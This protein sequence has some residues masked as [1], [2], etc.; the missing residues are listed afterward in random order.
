MQFEK[1]EYQ[2]EA[3]K[4][5]HETTARRLGVQM[6]TGSGKTY[7]L[8][9]VIKRWSREGKRVLFVVDKVILVD[10]TIDTLKALQIAVERL[11]G[12]KKYN[13]NANVFVATRQGLKSKDIE[14]TFDYVVYDEVHGYRT[15]SIFDHVANLYDNPQMIGLSATLHLPNGKPMAMF[16]ETYTPTTTARLIDD[17]HLKDIK[18]FRIQDLSD[19]INTGLVTVLDAGGD[20]KSDELESLMLTKDVAGKT[21]KFL[22][23]KKSIVFATGIKHAELLAEQYANRGFNTLTYHSKLSEKERTEAVNAMMR[24]DLDIIIGVDAL[25]SGFD[26]PII[27]TVVIARPT[28][29]HCIYRQMVGRGLRKFNGVD[30]CTVID[31]AGVGSVLGH[32]KD[33]VSAVVEA[34]TPPRAKT[35]PSCGSIDVRATGNPVKVESEMGAIL[36]EQDHVCND[37][38]TEFTAEESPKDNI[39]YSCDRL[40][41]KKLSI[42]KE[43]DTHLLTFSECPYCG[44]SNLVKSIELI[45]IK[46][47][48]VE[49]LEL[50]E[51]VECRLGRHMRPRDMLTVANERAKI[52]GYKGL[53]VQ[54]FDRIAEVIKIVPN[55][56]YVLINFL[57]TTT[58]L[59]ELIFYV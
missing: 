6:P 33:P 5:I 10:Q 41:A 25:I 3:I 31:A 34:K 48:E 9:E 16:D 55:F 26:A 29:S 18:V 58:N 56:K 47:E 7:V 42:F 54:Q 40:V 23:G 22:V 27:D 44:E 49:H 52:K 32:P 19:E 53:T 57:T 36:I 24:G 20:Y 21:E 51:D 38:Y 13:P 46:F 30:M 4:R 17:G 1:R 2:L 43:T 8:G 59:M 50:W 14:G 11:Q 37:C 35:C 45:D 12:N 39:C 28:K 15:S